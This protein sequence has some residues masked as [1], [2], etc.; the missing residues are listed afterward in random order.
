VN[1]VQQLFEQQRV[2]WRAQARPDQNA[3]ETAIAQLVA[4]AIRL[5]LIDRSWGS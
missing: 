4:K 2:F 1:R 5:D 3:V